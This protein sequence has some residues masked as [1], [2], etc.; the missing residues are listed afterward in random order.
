ME[1]PVIRL[2]DNKSVGGTAP[3]VPVTGCSCN[4]SQ[5][6]LSADHAKGQTT[7]SSQKDKV[8]PVILLNELYNSGSRLLIM[9]L[10]FAFI[11]YF[12]NGLIPAAWVASVFGGGNIYSVPLAATLG[13]PLYI[14][15]EASLPLIKSLIDHGMSQG[16]ALAF[17]ISGAG[18]SIGAITGAL[19]IA[20]W[21]VIGLVVAVLW[22]GAM[23]SGFVFD[24]ALLLKVF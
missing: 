19:T 4:S 17:L 11:G 18:T 23:L 15:S 7:A 13:L 24:L 10:G 12:L 5:T 6:T 22:A 16:A 3:A 20:R 21:R 2:N 14:N 8:S 9:F 1:M